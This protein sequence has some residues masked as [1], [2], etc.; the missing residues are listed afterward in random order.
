LIGNWP[1]E[2]LD[3]DMYLFETL[4]DNKYSFKQYWTLSSIDTVIEARQLNDFINELKL[5]VDY[6]Y[7]YKAFENRIPFECYRSAGP[8][9]ACEILTKKEYRKRSK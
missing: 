5:F 3:G 9:T 6:K 4:R 1:K 2:G 7:I 8:M